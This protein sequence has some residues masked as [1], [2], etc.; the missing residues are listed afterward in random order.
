MKSPATVTHPLFGPKLCGLICQSLG[1]PKYLEI[2]P[3]GLI[4]HDLFLNPVIVGQ[5]I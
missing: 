2:V 3:P 4:D 5:R 1:L